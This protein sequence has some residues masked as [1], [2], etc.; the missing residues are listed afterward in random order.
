MGKS[1]LAKEIVSH[2]KDAVYIDLEDPSSR[3]QLTDP[4]YFF[5][6]HADR[7]ICLDEVQSIPDIFV[8]IKSH[9][10]Q[11]ERP[12]K[13]L[14][15][16]SA[17][18]ALLKQTSESLAGRV[19]YKELLPFSEMELKNIP[20]NTLLMRGGF[21]RSVLAPN[22]PFSMTWRK[23]F[24]VTF[25]ERDVLQLIQG[26]SPSRM[27]SLWTMIAH[28]HGQL[29]N[30]SSLSRSIDVSNTT[31]FNYLNILEGAYMVRRVA[32]YSINIKKRLVKSRK[33]YLNDSGLLLAILGISS[34]NE[35]LNHP[36]R[37]AAMEGYVLQK[38]WLITMFGFI[39]H[40]KELS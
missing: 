11:K 15:L 10:D 31:I 14:L 27:H 7:L 5:Q 3:L 33:I 30:Y 16:G 25:L 2:Y 21:P 38:F 28:S 36:I 23:S 39:G 18:P 8:S 40:Q 6:T 4:H 20:W 19:I 13:F 29:L 26:I 37:G 32:P 17:S 35:L 1:T 34:F 9:I 24:I 12:G 22:D